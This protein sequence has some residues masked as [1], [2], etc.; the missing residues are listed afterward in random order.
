VCNVTGGLPPDTNRDEIVSLFSH[1]RVDDV[2][3]CGTY[4][5]VRFTSPSGAADAI[6]DMSGTSG[7]F[8]ST[9]A[10]YFLRLSYARRK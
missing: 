3:V 7:V 2:R 10:S 6:R 1:F 4:A 9:G 8:K 5:F